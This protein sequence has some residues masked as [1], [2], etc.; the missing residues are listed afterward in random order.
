MNL[1]FFTKSI[2]HYSF[3]QQSTLFLLTVLTTFFS[4]QTFAL[5]T[6]TKQPINIESDSATRDG[7]KE[8]TTYTGNVVVTQGS[9]KIQAK[10]V[11]IYTLKNKLQ[12]I[13]A[14]GSPVK[15]QQKPRANEENVRASGNKMTYSPKAKTVVLEG[16]AT[17]TQEGRKLTS[18]R[19]SYNLVRKF[20]E[21]KSSST[22]S[23]RVHVVIPPSE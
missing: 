16:N 9:L 8:L 18:D 10:Q 5:E 17:L 1:N 20:V 22:E 4:L 13:V 11:K 7:K 21:A 23:K 15:M 6:D 19:I 3:M 12:K 14:T 2:S